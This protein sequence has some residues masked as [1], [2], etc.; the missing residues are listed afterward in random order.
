MIPLNDLSPIF[1]GTLI[2]PSEIN[3]IA[4][5]HVIDTE[6]SIEEG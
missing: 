6:R 5:Y 1:N 3:F 2:P 4:E